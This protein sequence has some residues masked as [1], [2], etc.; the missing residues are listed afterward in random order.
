MT[1]REGRLAVGYLAVRAIIGIEAELQP[2]LGIR[3]WY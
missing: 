1:K 2:M 3:A